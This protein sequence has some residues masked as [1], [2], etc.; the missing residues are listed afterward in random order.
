MAKKQ[1]AP[2]A[3]ASKVL[4]GWIATWS[5]LAMLMFA[6]FVMLFSM[7]TLDMERFQQV[8][9]SFSGREIITMGGG[10]IGLDDLIGSGIMDLPS[11][12]E[13]VFDS[14]PS[15]EERHYALENLHDI[16]SD[17]RTY[18]AEYHGLDGGE[19]DVIVG[20]ES[21]RIIF[22]GG[23]LF[24]PGRADLRPDAFE[25]LDIVANAIFI[26]PE[27]FVEV[28]GHADN[29]PMRS[30]RF[31]SNWH[32]SSERAVSVLYYFVSQRSVDPTRISARGF[33]EYH[34]IATNDTPEGRARN[35]RVEINLVNRD[36]RAPQFEGI[37]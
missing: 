11:I 7:S 25:M 4:P 21:V 9:A 27:L 14:R 28:E 13:G 2:E 5:D 34:P 31:P 6:F 32:L 36:M 12:A 10:G 16:A 26:H 33:G 23:V 19:I 18:F 24:D 17:F 29:V 35:R 1:K 22:P 8:A 37:D 3:D 20:E 30:A 15:F